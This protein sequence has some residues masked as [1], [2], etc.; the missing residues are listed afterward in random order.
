MKHLLFTFGAVIAASMPLHLSYAQGAVK[1]SD[2]SALAPAS[3]TEPAT[4][5]ATAPSKSAPAAKLD[6]RTLD[7]FAAAY[8]EVSAI[9]TKATEELKTTTD[10]A[11]VQTVKDS[12]ETQARQAVE[13]NGLDAA[14]FNQIAQQVVSD[15]D[16]R[17][18]VVEKLQAHSSGT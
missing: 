16:L 18:R 11:K 5:S 9:Q 8:A 12:A 14:Q 1:P 15:Q 10:P 13:K 3:A 7:K 4:E 2:S 6:D 17:A